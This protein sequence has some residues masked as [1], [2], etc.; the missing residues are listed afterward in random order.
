[1]LPLVTPLNL[2]FCSLILTQKYTIIT[3]TYTAISVYLQ[4]YF[5]VVYLLVTPLLPK[6]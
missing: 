5:Q 2:T 3:E 4:S 6:T 1:M